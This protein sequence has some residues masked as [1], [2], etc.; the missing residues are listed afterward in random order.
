MFS[1]PGTESPN[2][3]DE[4]RFSSYLAYLDRCFQDIF[5]PPCTRAWKEKEDLPRGDGYSFSTLS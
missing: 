3:L 2:L 1:A 4:A 5:K